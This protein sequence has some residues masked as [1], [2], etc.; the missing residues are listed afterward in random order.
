MSSLGGPPDWG[1]RLSCCRCV[2][3]GQALGRGRDAAF[4]ELV[5]QDLEHDAGPLAAE[6]VDGHVVLCAAAKAQPQ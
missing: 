2:F 3:D 4:R 6:V 1:E 5:V